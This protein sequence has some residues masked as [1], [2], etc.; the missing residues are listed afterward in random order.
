MG[1]LPQ[2]ETV[3]RRIRVE[4]GEQLPARVS[5]F[6]LSNEIPTVT[7][8]RI[9]ELNRPVRESHPDGFLVIVR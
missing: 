1:A 5:V 6:V 2:Q 9:P 3:P 4:D 7:I 8:R